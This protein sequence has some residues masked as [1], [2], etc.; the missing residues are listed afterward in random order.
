MWS[1]PN[2]ACKQIETK[3][4]VTRNNVHT[5]L[6]THDHFVCQEALYE[7][8]TSKSCYPSETTKVSL[9]SRNYKK[10][11]N[12]SDSG[13]SKMQ[14]PQKWSVNTGKMQSNHM[15]PAQAEFQKRSQVNTMLQVQ[16][17]Q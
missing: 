4:E 13:S 16:T 7:H 5:L 6:P 10:Q 1:V 2:T 9:V 15:W 8:F 12:H 17:N 14:S 11:S 3:P